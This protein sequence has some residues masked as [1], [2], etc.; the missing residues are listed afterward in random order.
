MHYATRDRETRVIVDVT[1]APEFHLHDDH[2]AIRPTEVRLTY[3]A[4]KTGSDTQAEVF[5]PA[6]WPVAAGA[7]AR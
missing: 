7:P 6:S 4:D 5:G 1:D 2:P 3:Y